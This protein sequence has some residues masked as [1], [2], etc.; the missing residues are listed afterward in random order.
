MALG[1]EVYAIEVTRWDDERG[2]ALGQGAWTVTPCLLT[3]GTSPEDA[4]RALAAYR[5]YLGSIG[6]DP[7]RFTVRLQTYPLLPVDTLLAELAEDLEV[8]R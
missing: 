8:T 4:A 6:E 5:A 7:R 2:R 3:P 1:S